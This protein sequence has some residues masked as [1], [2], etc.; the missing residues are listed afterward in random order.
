MKYFSIWSICFAAFSLSKPTAS[1]QS[2]IICQH[3]PRPPFHLIDTSSTWLQFSF[4]A[5][6]IP[7]RKLYEEYFLSQKFNLR[8]SRK[9]AFG[10]ELSEVVSHTYPDTL[11]PAFLP[12]MFFFNVFYV[13][14]D[15]PISSFQFSTRIFVTM[16]NE[17][18]WMIK[19][20]FY[21]KSH[22]KF[23]MCIRLDENCLGWNSWNFL[24][25][26]FRD[27]RMISLNSALNF[28]SEMAKTW[29]LIF[30]SPGVFHYLWSDFCKFSV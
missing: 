27:L 11:N 2:I 25:Y 1:F 29:N 12:K 10:W 22:W 8:Y 17:K 28:L 24:Q 30:C 4:L 19:I 3:F 9:T 13:V 20:Y 14:I 23:D 16:N 6:R 15:S 26:H 5:Y 18:H 7:C 21:R